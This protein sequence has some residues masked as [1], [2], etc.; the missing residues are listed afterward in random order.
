MECTRSP[1]KYTPHATIS[2]HMLTQSMD[3]RLWQTEYVDIQ[4]ASH[5]TRGYPVCWKFKY[6][7]KKTKVEIVFVLVYQS[8]DITRSESR[9]C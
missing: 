9:V 7:P 2:D 5:F 4:Y 6:L 8:L 3:G 1:K